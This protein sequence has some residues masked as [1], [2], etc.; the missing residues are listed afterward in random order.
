MISLSIERKHSNIFGNLGETH[1]TV[2]AFE[3]HNDKKIGELRDADTSSFCPPSDRH[4]TSKIAASWFIKLFYS[5]GFVKF[6]LA[7]SSYWY[8]LKRSLSVVDLSL[9]VGGMYNSI[10]SKS[11]RNVLI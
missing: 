9:S 2:L 4:V 1:T 11:L 6:I 8:V 5:K 3:S 7:Q 10:S